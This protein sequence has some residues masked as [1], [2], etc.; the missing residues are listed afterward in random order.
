M[1]QCLRLLWFITAE[2]YLHS[3]VHQL[4][5]FQ[6]LQFMIVFTRSA[7]EIGWIWWEPGRRRLVVS[8]FLLSKRHP[9]T[10][11]DGEECV[12]NAFFTQRGAKGGEIFALD[13]LMPPIVVCKEWLTV[14]AFLYRLTQWVVVDVL[15]TVSW[16]F[17]LLAYWAAERQWNSQKIF[18]QN[19]FTTNF[20][21]L[22]SSCAAKEGHDFFSAVKM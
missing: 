16:E 6:T 18:Y 22:Y 19:T 5:M 20:G 3:P 9:S 10:D 4:H 1:I 15:L 14:A 2:F 8:L 12:H 17:S 13:N 11:S 21:T 7:F